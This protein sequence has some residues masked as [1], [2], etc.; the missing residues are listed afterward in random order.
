MPI[1][2]GHRPARI[3]STNPAEM[4]LECHDRI[5]QAMRGARG[6]AEVA[7]ADPAV[8]PTAAAVHRYFQV[9][10]PLHSQD[11]DNSLAPRLFS[12]GIP[13]DLADAVRAMH[14]QHTEIDAVL[15]R[16]LPLWGRLAVEPDALDAVRGD[17]AADTARL[18]ALWDVHLA[19]EEGFIFPRVGAELDEQARAE[20]A[21]EM[22][23]RRSPQGR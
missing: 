9:A 13:D 18:D 2:I 7:A 12:A 10:L 4:L 21:E 6:L 17:L 14:A 3:V 20:I 22:R 23:A 1:T 8:A 5:R 11:E 15:E 19:L 16:L